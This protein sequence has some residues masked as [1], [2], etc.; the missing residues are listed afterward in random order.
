MS[1]LFGLMG[2][3]WLTVGG[4]AVGGYDYLL[5]S[6][7]PPH[8]SDLLQVIPLAPGLLALLV[9]GVIRLARRNERSGL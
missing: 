5:F 4:L 8:M 6:H 1:M 9:S 2:L 7:R 3:A